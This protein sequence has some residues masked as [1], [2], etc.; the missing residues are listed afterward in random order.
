MKALLIPI[1]LCT[2]SPA[3]LYAVSL[4]ED[5]SASNK[6]LINTDEGINCDQESADAEFDKMLA[7]FSSINDNLTCR[8][9]A[10]MLPG[11]TEAYCQCVK[12]NNGLPIDTQYLKLLESKL[13]YVADYFQTEDL[14][15]GYLDVKEV[16]DQVFMLSTAFN[17]TNVQDVD[18]K[19]R[20]RDIINLLESMKTPESKCG[21]NKFDQVL[22]LLHR[23]AASIFSGDDNI[24]KLVAELP[25]N[26][27]A[28][29]KA[30]EAHIAKM[31]MH[32]GFIQEAM[33]EII[34]HLNTPNSQAT[35][36]QVQAYSELFINDPLFKNIK[37]QL[38]NGVVINPK[39]T[40][41]ISKHLTGINET[42]DV[43]QYTSFG[44]IADALKKEKVYLGA[45]DFVSREKC[46]SIKNKLDLLCEK[47]VNKDNYLK[48]MVEDDPKTL[49]TPITD[50]TKL[51]YE[52]LLIAGS[53]QCIGAG[54]GKGMIDPEA[55]AY[56]KKNLGFL[57]K[58]DKSKVGDFLTDDAYYQELIYP[59][60]S[61]QGPT[62][63]GMKDKIKT[64]DLKNRVAD[65]VRK[66]DIKKKYASD[67]ERMTTVTSDG[68]LKFDS[69]KGLFSSRAKSNVPSRI[70]PMSERA[71][72][73]A[74]VASEPLVAAD[75]KISGVAMNSYRNNL[76]A[77]QANSVA[78][79]EQADR[80]DAPQAAKKANDSNS[81]FEERLAKIFENQNAA[82]AAKEANVKDTHES[83]SVASK[84]Q[85]YRYQQ[86]LEQINQ[87][88]KSLE[89]LKDEKNRPAVTT[90]AT[91]QS[92]ANAQQNN[93]PYVPFKG[94][95]T[96]PSAAA[97]R[98]GGASTSHAPV[99]GR[100]AASAGNGS[101]GGGS[102]S[103]ST[104]SSSYSAPSE[105]AG[106]AKIS[107]AFSSSKSS[108]GGGSFTLSREEVGQG[109][110][111][112]IPASSF[113]AEDT[114]YLKKLYEQTKGEPIFL[115]QTDASG[116]EQ[117]V[118]LEAVVKA[119]G[120]I[121][122]IPVDKKEAKAETKQKSK[123]KPSSVGEAKK[124]EVQK[125]NK[126]R[127]KVDD[128]KSLL[129]EKL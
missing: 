53:L 117:F 83:K 26:S 5:Q 63:T 3:S 60:M 34:Q 16:I 119:D 24:K 126:K 36:K 15:T 123:R 29:H 88:K 101:S 52:D 19:C 111:V 103:S 94:L 104:A 96:A 61:E 11:D 31:N 25:T 98:D 70:I 68:E 33:V 14:M 1:I 87:L 120:S 128:L 43:L 67:L 105:S 7:S 64:N 109:E 79:Q 106:S 2:L 10:Q 38:P 6:K 129:G 21:G 55:E 65:A 28:F 116:K 77:A 66:D 85:D 12:A 127:T 17:Y 48:K 107:S 74:P 44:H 47:I 32:A 22:G 13:S 37:I 69:S 78:R 71:I 113:N 97:A 18:M 57:L 100:S 112:I 62:T 90:T 27:P 4:L 114:E 45:E 42:N 82:K 23:N 102:S 118:M 59:I 73:Q 50:Y 40:Y 124:E 80:Y 54:H 99:A 108:G 20:D 84:G 95:D 76:P 110:K 122:Y 41:D 93:R 115:S 35:E 30:N 121:E 51:K 56:L 8:N 49:L 46:D 75:P 86:S 89:E 92:A 81:S 39:G 91:P 72:A 9:T 125:N 58:L